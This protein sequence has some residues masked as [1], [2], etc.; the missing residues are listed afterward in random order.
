MQIHNV[1]SGYTD[2]A[3]RRP[4]E[5]HDSIAIQRGE[6]NGSAEAVSGLSSTIAAR[7]VLEKYDVTE[8]TPRQLTEM[9]QRLL[10]AGAI[11]QQDFDQLA[12]IRLDLDVAGIDPDESVDLLQF[13]RDKVD[14]AR[15][16]STH[17]TAVPDT[18]LSR[19]DWIEKFALVQASPEGFGLD[20]LA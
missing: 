13:Y 9:V 4:A 15:R 17:A 5:Y 2:P 14:E 16:Q 12:A 20:A 7:N 6:E 18:L 10:D 3:T 8:I 1:L 19:L 11:S